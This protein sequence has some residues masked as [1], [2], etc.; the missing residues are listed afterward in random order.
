VASLRVDYT[1]DIISLGP[2]EEEAHAENPADAQA[3]R[4]RLVRPGAPL[5]LEAAFTGFGHGDGDEAWQFHKYLAGHRL[6]PYA[7][8]VTF[9][10]NGTDDDRIST[11]AKDD[12][13][14]AT[15]EQVAPIARR[16]GVETFILDD[17]W[18]AASGDWEPDSPEHPETR[19]KFP[20][21]FP[22]DS[23]A[24][25]RKA[26]APMRLG[27]WMSP[28]SFNPASETFKRHPDWACTPVGDGTAAASAA[29]PDDGSNEAGIGLWG[30]KAIPWI[31]SRIRD[32]IDSWGVTYFKFDFLV[33]L[34]CAGQGDL[35]DYREAFMAM[36]DRLERDHPDVT[37]QIDETNDYRLFPFESVVRGPSW[38]QN[39]SPGPEQLLHNIWNLSPYV[40]AFSLGQHALGGKAYEQYPVD[41]L[42]AVALLSHVTFFSDLR[43]LPDSVIDQARPW[44]DF[45]K[46]NRG[47]L[48]GVVYPLLGDP[49]EKGW[50]ALQSW[51]PEKGQGALLAFRQDSD[52]ES[53]TIA[54]RDVPPGRTFHLFRAPGG[55]PAG[56]VTSE[57]LSQGIQ[58]RLPSKR[59]AEVLTIK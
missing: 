44:L 18:Q 55:E 8:A 14:L 31:E 21:R 27:L 34:D 25:V 58:V 10:S 4:Q 48:G 46:S 54:L 40:P 12:M 36:L 33:W 22:D 30:P 57:Q 32:A 20:P 39:G 52:E 17:G 45:Y 1:R 13:D 43:T 35:Y 56:T 23:F 37:F 15:V 50:T 38:F 7:H 42:M 6:H 24:A 47:L 26:I 49:L 59:S 29:Q 28:M 11:G 2:F 41:E 53:R 19:G 5:A 51:D 16:L 3:G 9:N